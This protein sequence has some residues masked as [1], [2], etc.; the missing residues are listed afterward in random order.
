MVFSAEN[1]VVGLLI[2][3]LL[4]TVNNLILLQRSLQDDGPW[5]HRS[6]HHNAPDPSQRFPSVSPVLCLGY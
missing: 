3:V 2:L 4:V 1:R 6:S 5:I